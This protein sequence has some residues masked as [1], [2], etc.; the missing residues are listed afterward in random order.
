MD[1][2]LPETKQPT[3]KD[4]INF[5]ILIGIQIQNAFN[6]KAAQL[7]LIPL[8]AWLARM[9]NT[10]SHMEYYLGAAI[11]IPYLLLS[12]FVGWFAD[13]F[14]KTRIIQAMAFLQ[15]GVMMAMWYFLVKQQLGATI[16]L[17]CIFAIQATILSPARKGVI[18]DMIGSKRIGFASGIVEVAGIF[19]LLAAQIGIFFWFDGLLERHKD[20]WHAAAFPTMVL[21]I[22]AVPVA[23]T[24]L[25]LPKYPIGK[26][27]TF[28]PSLFYEHFIQL[29]FL[30]K[31][32][33]LRLSEIGI[34]YFWFLASVI[35]LITI[36]IAKDITGGGEGMGTINGILT[37]WM[38]GGVIIGG[39]VGSLLC[40]GKI[41]LGLI[42]LG[43]IGITL[44]CLFMAFFDPI[45][46]LNHNQFFA[47]KSLPIYIG[48]ALIGGFAAIYL[49]PLNAY[50]Q[51][52]CD[53]KNRGN[54]I[55]AANL[56]DMLM[57]LVAV[58]F[59][60][61]LKELFCIQ[62][63]FL[64]L[65]FMGLGITILSLR[66]IPR[67][68]VRMIGLW[69]MRLCYKPRIIRK[70]DFP[71]YGGVLI[72]S[73]HVTYA[74][75]LFLSM[76]TPRPIRFIVAEEFVAMK[77]LGWFLE[78]FNCL[79]IS[80]KKPR[81]AISKSIQSLKEGEV[82]CIFPEGQLT[83]T[84]TLCAMRRGLELLAR[85]SQAKVIPV[86]IDGLWGSIFSYSENRFFSKLPKSIPG[87]FTAAFGTPFTSE[88]L[89]PRNTM[90]RLRELASDCIEIS[91]HLGRD[92]ILRKLELIGTKKFIF[93]KQ[94]T[95]TG[96]QLAAHLI[97]KSPEKL[98]PPTAAWL[99][100][101]IAHLKDEEILNPLWINAQQISRT[102]SLQPGEMML[103]SIGHEE[104]SQEIV[105][106]I[107]W[108][109]LSGTPIYL[110]EDEDDII[111][112]N[113][114]QMAGGTYLRQRLY[115][116]IPQKRIVFYDF[117]GQSDLAL[118]NTRWKPCFCN[119]Q[120]II[121]SMSMCK[122]V[123]KLD[124]GTVQLGMRPRTKGRLLPGFYLKRM[125]EQTDI[126]SGVSL[127]REY[128]LPANLYLDESGF[129]A[130]LQ[131][132]SK[133]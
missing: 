62:N 37:I 82:V 117:S 68:F 48:F 87:H 74:D 34:S 76:V 60:L 24:S 41:E 9:A 36:Q 73:N 39:L 4:W 12:P 40:R 11:V 92:T 13:R 8:A 71:E 77:F 21:L 83:R 47:N 127:T 121:I 126:L 35:A 133:S 128:S 85:K 69:T 132:Y 45:E 91:A 20:G 131:S 56:M 32:R 119:P 3:T 124:D 120:G 53:P 100:L 61:V 130:E 59:Q 25:V 112:E 108:P 106:S 58:G 70:E 88:E 122:S 29:K 75:A 26:T 67:E 114:C 64:I 105:L 55:A 38:S 123:Y 46:L 104:E 15:I 18:K 110:L 118:P 31:Q 14:C 50:L 51:D 96:A 44:G 54:V 102:N 52:N 2:S 27:R 63:Q 129:L 116:L 81:E 94:G 72:V 109:I 90:N 5:W 115:H 30:W 101:L 16:V 93:T 86:Y 98:P 103:T 95:Y 113:I 1:E 125:G 33:N 19:A 79:P 65:A 111:P 84:G 42:P 89:N 23:F 6:E 97:N 22:I 10:E 66:L 78:L 17:F 80:S 107:L 49:I 57:A 28:S 43:A 7:L 99:K